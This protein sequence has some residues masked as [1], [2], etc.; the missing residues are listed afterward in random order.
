MTSGLQTNTSL[1]I[2][3]G[4]VRFSHQVGLKFDLSGEVGLA[5]CPQIWGFV[6]P[7][8]WMLSKNLKLHMVPTSTSQRQHCYGSTAKWQVGPNST[9]L[10]LKMNPTSS[11]NKAL[12]SSS[13]P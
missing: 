7:C 2:V 6:S 5:L 1:E 13:V 4:H 10:L 8:V 3:G 12:I 9:L 11:A